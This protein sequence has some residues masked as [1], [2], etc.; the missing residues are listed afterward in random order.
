LS[1]DENV[2]PKFWANPKFFSE[3]YLAATWLGLVLLLLSVPFSV[4]I[5]TV[6][7]GEGEKNM[8]K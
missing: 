7:S 6:A 1:I 3:K 4:T 5:A 2:R 8:C